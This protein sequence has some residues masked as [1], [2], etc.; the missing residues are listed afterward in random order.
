MS[1]MY[2]SQLI[3]GGQFVSSVFS[4]SLF[5][6]KILFVANMSF[7]DIS[8]YISK[9]YELL[10][11]YYNPI[12]LLKILIIFNFKYPVV[13]QIASSAV[14]LKTANQLLMYFFN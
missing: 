6:E 5:P 11:N 4:L 7:I 14:L 12:L 9:I 10:Q 2:S 8:M 3:A 13:T 1:S